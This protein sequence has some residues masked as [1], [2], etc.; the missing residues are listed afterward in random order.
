MAVVALQTRT[1]GLNT[2]V[3]PK[4]TNTQTQLTVKDLVKAESAAKS[5]TESYLKDISN[6]YLGTTKTVKESI[7][8]VSKYNNVTT[9]PTQAGS[10]PANNGISSQLVSSTTLYSAN[11]AIN[12]SGFTFLYQYATSQSVI[13]TVC[14]GDLYVTNISNYNPYYIKSGGGPAS[15]GV[16][17]AMAITD[18]KRKDMN[19]GYYTSSNFAMARKL[20]QQSTLPNCVGWAHGRVLEVWGLAKASGYIKQI[21]GGGYVIPSENNRP[22]SGVVNSTLI[23]HNT[24]YN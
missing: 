10:T 5:F 2:L 24:A 8:T 11:T 18:E 22:I 23:P 20:C 3:T 6:S 9:T 12:G 14:S 16:S 21:A 4:N 1:I 15:N 19:S 17:N 7:N 13:K